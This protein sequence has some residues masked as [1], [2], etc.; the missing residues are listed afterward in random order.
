MSLSYTP[1]QEIG[2]KANAPLKA[3]IQK[4]LV[5]ETREIA[6]SAGEK[7][8]NMME[9][10]RLQD[11]T[12]ADQRRGKNR[13]KPATPRERHQLIVRKTRQVASIAKD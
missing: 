4:K 10:D 2:C 5:A 11:G 12:A 9:I 13:C 7:N 1:I 3:S 6:L 8:K